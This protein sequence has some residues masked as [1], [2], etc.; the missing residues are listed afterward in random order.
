V[1]T[2]AG[3]YSGDEDAFDMRKAMPRDVQRLSVVPL[4]RDVHPHELEF[5]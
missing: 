2:P 4:K 3:Y 1:P 5:D